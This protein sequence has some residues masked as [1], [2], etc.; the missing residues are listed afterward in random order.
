MCR[1]LKVLCVAP[2]PAR[3]AELKRAAVGADW[4]LTAGAI[5]EVAALEQLEAERPHVVVAIGGLDGF[6]R[7]ARRRYPYLRV[8]TDHE[9]PDA[10]VVVADLDEV[11]PAIRGLPRPAGP[12]V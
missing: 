9:T 12:V 1:S 10:S 3:L 2:D 8:V 4:E 6:V 5:D 7:E 11:R